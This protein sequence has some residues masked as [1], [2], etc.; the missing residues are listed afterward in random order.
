MSKAISAQQLV[1]IVPNVLGVGGS[2]LAL[3]GLLLTDSPRVPVGSVLAFASAAAVVAYFGATAPEA[4]AAQIYFAGPD[5]ALARPAQLLF[6]QYNTSAVAGYFRGGPGIT[7]AQVQAITTGTLTV[8]A[9]GGASKTSG[10]LNLSS[11]TSLS[12]AA[13]LIQAAFTTP[14]FTVTYDSQAG[15]FVITSNTTGASSSIAVTS[16]AIATALKLST[17]AGAVTSPGRAALTD[18]SAYMASVVAGAQNWALFTTTFA[19][20]NA[21]GLAFSNWAAGTNKRYAYVHW[22][23]DANNLAVNPTTTVA[24]QAIAAGNDGTIFVYAPVNLY[25]MGAFVL[26]WAASLNFATANGRTT[27]AFRSQGGLSPDVTDDTTYAALQAN[28]LNCYGLFST[29]ANSYAMFSDGRISGK[30]LWADSYVNQIWLNDQ[31]Q[32][33]YM[34]FLANTNNIPYNTVGYTRVRAAALDTIRAAISFGAI[35]S[36]VNL[37]AS[38]VAAINDAAG[39]EASNAIINDGYYLAVTDPGATAR[40]QRKSPNINLWYADGQSVQRISVNSSEVQ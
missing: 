22:T 18:P 6:A 3:S 38:Q 27:L 10:A 14:G 23:A 26:S 28:G 4:I 35:R 21:D 13:A 17:D 34:S 15:A 19:P 30:Y 20:S 7:L 5:G 2:A 12:N 33:S 29:A 31:L 39:V 25:K 36:G 9:D 8:T 11:A 40:T 32:V 1:N 24:A 16:G 37:S